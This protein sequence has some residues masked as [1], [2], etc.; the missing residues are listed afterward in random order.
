MSAV[1]DERKRQLLA[2]LLKE[3]GID[4]LR[5]SRYEL[6]KEESG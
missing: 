6:P 2:L 3:E 4:P 5:C 1:L